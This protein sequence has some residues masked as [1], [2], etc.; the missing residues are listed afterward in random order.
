MLVSPTA[1]KCPRSSFSRTR[2]LS[3][4]SKVSTRNPEP[5]KKGFLDVPPGDSDYECVRDVRVR[6]ST[7]SLTDYDTE[8]RIPIYNDVLIKSDA[9]LYIKGARGGVDPSSLCTDTVFRRKDRAEES[10]DYLE[11]QCRWTSSNDDPPFHLYSPPV[12]RSQQKQHRFC[13]VK[14][15]SSSTP[16]IPISISPCCR[17]T[18]SVSSAKTSAIMMQRSRSSGIQASALPSSQRFSTSLDPSKQ[19]P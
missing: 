14:T 9:M 2:L 13:T 11:N 16:I 8:V 4:M 15:H 7:V 12:E 1:L 17:Q 6:C 18:V 3:V 19:A 5:T 10:N